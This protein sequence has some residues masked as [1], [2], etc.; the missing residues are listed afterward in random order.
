MS[1]KTASDAPPKKR[2][3]DRLVGL[4]SP[5]S[6]DEAKK[7][8][9]GTSFGT[10]EVGALEIDAAAA[11]AIGGGQKAANNV[12]ISPNLSMEHADRA[13]SQV[14]GSAQGG[15][16]AAGGNKKSGGLA[17]DDLLSETRIGKK[18]NSAR[19]SSPLAKVADPMVAE[20]QTSLRLE[21]QKLVTEMVMRKKE[22]QQQ[23][24]AKA[25]EEY[26]R[27]VEL[28]RQAEEKVGYGRRDLTWW[29]VESC[30]P[31]V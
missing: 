1:T 16:H 25:R 13:A 17:V 3:I 27:R 18:A 6:K 7:K 2:V 29:T 22:Q 19:G 23:D 11:G 14:G 5:R 24:K 12:Y 31:C 15:E 21:E 9:G 4:L 30:R 10:R 28:E 26:Q 20:R 8:S